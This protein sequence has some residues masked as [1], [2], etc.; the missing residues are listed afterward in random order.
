MESEPP[1]EST[2]S[3]LI[4]IATLAVLFLIMVA[5]AFV[6]YG[7]IT[8]GTG[9]AT[10]APTLIPTATPAPTPSIMPTPTPTPT[11]EPTTDPVQQCQ[12]DVRLNK[13]LSVYYNPGIWED[14]VVYEN[15][16]N[17]VNRVYLFDTKTS[18]E[19]KIAEGNIMSYGC[20]GNGKVVLIDRDNYKMFVYDIETNTNSTLIL[21]ENKPRFNPD[22]YGRRI[23]FCQDDGG[24]NDHYGQ[25]M[26]KFSIYITDYVDSTTSCIVPDISEPTDIR[27]Y[28]NYVVWT[29]YDGQNSDIY[30]FN[31][32]KG[33][34]TKITDGNAKNDHP[35][36]YDNY[37][38][39]HSNAKDGQHIYSYN[40][41]TEETRMISSV[42]KQYN[43]DIYGSKVVYDDSRIGNWNI[44]IY[45]LRTGQEKW[46]TYETHD[47][48]NPHIYGNKVVYLDNRNGGWDVYMID[49]E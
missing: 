15:S 20:I 21:E 17:G 9:N 26:S 5:C 31:I 25:W 47:Q 35:R 30:M 46:L 49:I 11:P 8:Q 38:I 23:A 29:S 43:A 14:Y 37:V 1:K 39:Y 16:Q 24:Y 36:I 42:G 19:I 45:D 22:I 28:D 32:P 44:Y 18:T 2:G 48:L 13:E 41:D 3:K 27:L 12:D 10:T 7:Y 34:M 33:S 40:I 4:F 6:I